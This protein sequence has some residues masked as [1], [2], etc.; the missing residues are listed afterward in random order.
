MRKDLQVGKI[1]ESK[2]RVSRNQPRFGM[3]MT[4]R[5]GGRL[6]SLLQ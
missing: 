4:S 6:L 3:V 1:Y 2:E 5:E